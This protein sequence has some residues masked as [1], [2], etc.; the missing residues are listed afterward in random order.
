MKGHRFSGWISQHAPVSH[1][2]SNP[3]QS[4][5]P[6]P[7]SGKLDWLLLVPLSFPIS[8]GSG[9]VGQLQNEVTW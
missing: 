3:H 6:C 7:T 2:T 1:N 5:K 4:I 8:K 9:E